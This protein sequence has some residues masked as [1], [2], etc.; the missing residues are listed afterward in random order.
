MNALLRGGFVVQH[1][2]GLLVAAIGIAALAACGGGGGGGRS[3]PPSVPAPPLTAPTSAPA[4]TLQSVSGTVVSIPQG[5]YGTAASPQVPL[6]GATVVIGNALIEGATLPPT[7]P[8]NDVV[9]TSDATGRFSAKV[10]QPA[11]PPATPS[12]YT[13]V[14][15]YKN[16]FNV[17]QPS[18]GY[19]VMVFPAGAD[20]LSAGK[21]LPV[22]TFVAVTANGS[23]GTFRSTT[24][25]VDEAGWLQQANLDRGAKGQLPTV[26]DENA[27]EK[28]RQHA[29]DMLVEFALCDYNLA[30]QGPQTQYDLLGGLGQDLSNIAISGGQPTT[31]S[32]FWHQVEATFVAGGSLAP[33]GNYHY[34]NL[35]YPKNLW[36]GLAVATGPWTPYPGEQYYAGDMESINLVD[37]VSTVAAAD[38]CPAGIVANES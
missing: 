37:P 11:P 21:H 24:A 1:R 13:F 25:S 19:F 5:S 9:A 17:V 6:A 18:S 36:M 32:S 35:E 26:F 10:G 23:L 22:H 2:V 4:P 29:N 31:V 12:L 3:A 38:S 7:L 8:G 20:G 28:A 14:L 16:V 33:P 30:N 34:E 15:P 27:Q